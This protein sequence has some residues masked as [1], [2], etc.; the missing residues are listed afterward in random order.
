MF[1]QIFSYICKEWELACTPCDHL[2]L[3]LPLV[4]P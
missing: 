2:D 4:W 1:S 3:P